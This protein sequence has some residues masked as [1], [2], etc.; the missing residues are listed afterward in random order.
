MKAVKYVLG[1]DVT[2]DALS[3]VSNLYCNGPLEHDTTYQVWMRAFTNG[4]YS[5][6]DCIIVIT[7]IFFRMDDDILLDNRII[8]NFFFSIID[9]ELSVYL[10]IG[11]I[12]GILTAGIVSAV[13]LTKMAQ[14]KG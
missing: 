2:C 14:Y 5:D 10:V 13:L 1:D 7:G 9:K 4:G 8:C 3:A 12:L 6:S 11:V